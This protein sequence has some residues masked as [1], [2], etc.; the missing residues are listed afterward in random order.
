[1]PAQKQNKLA[2]VRLLNG[3]LLEGKI[4]VSGATCKDL[5]DEYTSIYWNEDGTDS[6]PGSQDHCADA[7]LYAWR[8]A[9]H[10]LSKPEPIAPPK[11]GTPEWFQAEEER[12]LKK[13]LSRA[14]MRNRGFDD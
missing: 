1:M 4:L 13:A 14:D 2:Y 3:D 6:A 9:R 5:V 8:D 11:R 12:E 10:W 7:A